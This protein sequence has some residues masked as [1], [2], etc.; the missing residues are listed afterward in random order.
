M[1]DPSVSIFKTNSQLS[2]SIASKAVLATRRIVHR[3]QKWESR[4]LPLPLG[5]EKI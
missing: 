1:I 4:E 3:V 2:A 5:G